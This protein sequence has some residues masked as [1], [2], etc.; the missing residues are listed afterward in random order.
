MTIAVD[1]KLNISLNLEEHVQIAPQYI[2][3][4]RNPN[5]CLTKEI[6]I[7]ANFC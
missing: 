2:V 1:K 4:C 6:N 3:E 5:K 7:E